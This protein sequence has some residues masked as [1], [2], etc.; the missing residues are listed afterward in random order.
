MS[1]IRRADGR[2]LFEIEKERFPITVDYGMPLYEMWNMARKS[3]RWLGSI[4]LR[5]ITFSHTAGIHKF[6]CYY[7][8]LLED[9]CHLWRM[10]EDFQECNIVPADM[11]QFFAFCPANIRTE[12]TREKP[13]PIVA[14]A[15][16]STW[17]CSHDCLHEMVGVHWDSCYHAPGP[18][19]GMESAP[20]KKGT[21]FL[22]ICQ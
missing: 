9:D 2:Q 17:R 6:D 12:V 19:L 15:S 1:K 21:R 3:I 11:R 10:D 13:A 8:V 22:A 5:G 20:F 18:S 14:A 16:G 7:A 4:E